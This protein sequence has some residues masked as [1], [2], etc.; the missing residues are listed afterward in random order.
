MTEDENNLADN[1]KMELDKRE[2]E[3]EELKRK[4]ADVQALVAKY[5]L[6]LISLEREAEKL[7]EDIE[8]RH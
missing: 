6:E 1:Y 7:K 4:E 2:A 8:L 5:K 3:T